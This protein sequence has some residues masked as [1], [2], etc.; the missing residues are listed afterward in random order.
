M[1]R[2]RTGMLKRA[3]TEK[4]FKHYE[5]EAQRRISQEDRLGEPSFSE[6]KRK[7][8]RKLSEAV[9]TL[10]TIKDDVESSLYKPTDESED[11]EDNDLETPASFSIEPM[12]SS[13]EESKAAAE[14]EGKGSRKPSAAPSAASFALSMRSDDEGAS[15]G[16]GMDRKVSFHMGAGGAG[17]SSQNDDDDDDEEKEER[18]RKRSKKHR[19]GSRHLPLE[20]DL[21]L[22]RTK[23]SELHMDDAVRPTEEEEA[24]VL[25]NRDVEDMASHRRD[26]MPGFS[27]HKINKAKASIS[28]R[29]PD[30][31]QEQ[32]GQHKAS[33][34]SMNKV[35]HNS[36]LRSSEH[37]FD[38]HSFQMMTNLYDKFDHTPHDLFVEMDELEGEEWVEQA[39]WIKYEEAREEGAERWGKAH[40]SSLS[41]HSLINLRLCLEE[42]KCAN[43]KIRKYQSNQ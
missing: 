41:F 13:D 31:F 14:K 32:F 9:S 19:R 12:D 29:E 26:N 15:S 6:S 24:A 34:I 27:R 33:G 11:N 30:V 16:T 35:S 38:T 18:K 17:M 21:V 5:K 3:E 40:V 8:S 42:C 10:P 2:M 22:R 36:F 1:S 25:A 20:A 43:I 28:Y 37:C 7:K 39:R 4:A 23:G